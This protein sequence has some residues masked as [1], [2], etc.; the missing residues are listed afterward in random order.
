MN[1]TAL[2][3]ALYAT[4][5][6]ALPPELRGEAGGLAFALGLAPSAEALW[7]EVFGDPV[8]L[9]AP[10]LVADATP[11]LGGAVI[12]DA[13]TAHLLAVIAALG[14]ERI[15]SGRVAASPGVLAVLDHAR[16]G[17]DGAIA[18]VAASEA[19]A[20]AD[21]DE[22]TRA[23]GD[24]ERGLLRSGGAAA[25]ARY[26]ALALAKQRLGAPA[27]LALARAAGWEPRRQRI[28]AR[29][30]DTIGVGLQ[31]QRDATG[32]ERERARGGSWAVAL[33]GGAAHLLDA[34]A[35]ADV[36]AGSGASIR[37]TVLGSGV[38]A[39]MLDAAARRCRAARRRAAA[40]GATRLAA[41]AEEREGSL[42]ELA[43]HERESPG[44]AGRSRAL[45]AWARSA[46]G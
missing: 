5:V 6:G 21:A 44:Y 4:F 46:P 26:L 2:V 17:R 14:A 7:S 39:W 19:R 33:A 23:A 18:R 1:R 12:H 9:G 25:R 45:S 8:T 22:A 34:D 29:L 32:W 24:E 41:W 3:D 42:R 43:R 27:S 36:G 40:L 28:L 31:L 20:Y 13:V 16:R 11:G 35:D 37:S 38:L 30:L 15:A 10:L